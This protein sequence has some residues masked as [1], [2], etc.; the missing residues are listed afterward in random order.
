MSC[1]VTPY[2]WPWSA[3]TTDASKYYA[4]PWS[5]TTTDASKYEGNT[6]FG[7][8]FDEFESMFGNSS[9]K[10]EE[11]NMCYEIEVPGFNK[12]NI[13]V[14]IGNGVV[15]ITGKR[16]TRSKSHAGQR[17]IYKRLSIARGEDVEAEVKDGILYITILKNKEDV[18]E[19]AVK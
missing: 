13:K 10:D 8:L 3:T 1:S 4:W 12:D 7:K 6:V 2:A 9:Y 11:G 16:E 14:S 5:A 18:K 17:E 15:D 19:V